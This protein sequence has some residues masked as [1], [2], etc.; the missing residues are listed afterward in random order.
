MTKEE[1]VDYIKEK[2]NEGWRI[3]E[4]TPIEQVYVKYLGVHVIFEKGTERLE[5][6]LMD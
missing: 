6:D 1:R 5:V 2:E 4:H 3:L